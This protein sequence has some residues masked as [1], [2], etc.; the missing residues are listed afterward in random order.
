LILTPLVALFEQ[1]KTWLRA[2]NFN[3]AVRRFPI[4]RIEWFQDELEDAIKQAGRMDNPSSWVIE[5]AVA[6]AAEL[7]ALRKEIAAVPDPKLSLIA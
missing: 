2:T 7:D 3:E 4:H 6:Y 5:K 1:V